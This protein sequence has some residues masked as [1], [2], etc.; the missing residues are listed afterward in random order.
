MSST[1]PQD[2]LTISEVEHLHRLEVIVQRGLR[3]DVEIGRALDEIRA[4]KLHRDTHGSFGAYLRERWGVSIELDDLA[5][6]DLFVVEMRVTLRK[7]DDAAVLESQATLDPLPVEKVVD[8]EL[9][10]ML[11]RLLT[12][13]SGTIGRVVD[14]LET[15]GTVIDDAAL[16]QLRDDVL[17]VDEELTILKAMLLGDIDW[18]SELQQMLGSE[19]PPLD[20]DPDAD[21]D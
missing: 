21:G 8:E 19:I 3:A 12:Q 11:R 14:E 16:S 20:H 4:G 5:A 15:R 1:D 9:V 18:D 6:D 10:P 7:Q 17:V 2:H 13:S